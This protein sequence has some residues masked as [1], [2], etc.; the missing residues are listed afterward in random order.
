MI[1]IGGAGK[2]GKVVELRG[3]DRES[4]SSVACVEWSSNG[5]TNVYRVG[6]K[7]KVDLKSIQEGAGGMYYR[8]HLAILGFFFF[9]FNW[10]C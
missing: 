10:F 2:T 3:W 4:G 5:T 7:G 9:N 6:H 8:D 1:E